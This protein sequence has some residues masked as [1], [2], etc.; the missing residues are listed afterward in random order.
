MPRVLISQ[1]SMRWVLNAIFS[2]LANH[3]HLSLLRLSVEPTD[4]QDTLV[5]PLELIGTN[6]RKLSILCSKTMFQALVPSLR[7]LILNSPNMTALAL[8]GIFSFQ[9]V[10][11][12]R[13]LEGL[14]EPRLESLQVEGWH[15]TSLHNFPVHLRSLSCLR[16][17][18]QFSS[19]TH[20]PQEFWNLLRTERVKL[21]VLEINHVNEAQVAYL[22]SYS[23]LE[24]LTYPSLHRT[25]SVDPESCADSVFGT[26]LPM[27]F[28]T[29]TSLAIR[30]RYAG[31]W[32][33]EEHNL[34]VLSQ[35]SHLRFLSLCVACQDFLEASEYISR[36]EIRTVVRTYCSKPSF[37]FVD[38]TL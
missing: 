36:T 32:C 12:D 30:P 1:W 11:I 21:K 22:A 35:C 6:L 23:G 15:L 18:D 37:S 9:D 27:H 4:N 19:E 3:Q 5:P 29:L 10:R 7:K 34:R 17:T 25:F 13:L 28:M 16:M 33:V 38:T 8:S 26:V 2:S 14:T 31:R 20:L 24:E